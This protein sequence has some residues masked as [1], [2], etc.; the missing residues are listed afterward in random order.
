M[1][2]LA[3]EVR[4]QSPWTV[5]FADNIVIC[6]ESRVQVERWS[7]APER[8]GMKVSPSK[9]EYMCV[10][11]KDQSGAP[12]LEGGEIMGGG[13]SVHSNKE[14]EREGK[15]HV[16]AGSGTFKIECMGGGLRGR[17]MTRYMDVVGEDM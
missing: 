10:N 17:P 12:R 13:A 9:T 2:R 1:D 11:E 14:C 16:W 15:K 7:Y 8:R 3:D 5:M 4:Q 6:S